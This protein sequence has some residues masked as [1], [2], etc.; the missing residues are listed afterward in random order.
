MK[1]NKIK[2]HPNLRPFKNSK[3]RHFIWGLNEVSFEISTEYVRIYNFRPKQLERYYYFII[4]AMKKIK[5]KSLSNLQ[6]FKNVKV[7]HS[8]WG[9]NEV[10]FE[11]STEYVQMH[12]FRPKQ[13]ERYNYF[14]IYAVKKIKIKSHPN[15]RP[16]KNTK[17][18]LFIWGLNE[19]SFEIST[20]HVRIYNFRPKQ[21]ERYSY[22]IVYAMKKIKIK[23]HPNLRPFK[24]TKV[25]HFIWGL[26]EV[27]FEIST[28]YVRIYNFRPKQLE[29][30]YYFIIYAMKK[31]KIKSLSNLQPFKNVKVRHS[32]WGFNEVSF[33]ISTEYVQMHNF[34]PK[35]LE[36]YNYF[37]I[38]AVK[39]IK[40]KSHPN[41]RPFKNTKVR[42][43]IWGLNEVSFEISTEYVRIYNFRPKQ[44]ERYYYFIIYAMKKIKI[45]SLSNLQPF[46]NVKVRHSIW[47]FNEVSFEISTE[48]VQMHNFQPKQLER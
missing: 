14:I 8:I 35:Q 29:R 41:L 23:S 25:R 20:E 24:N 4:Y 32:I 30:Y 36:R 46:K 38:Y 18:R 39:K 42:H 11:I 13:L 19:V 31:I 21:L 34:R 10:S 1:K 44:L 22:F 12:N 45:K 37:I 7:R 16:F 2:S 33:E 5:I 26:N 17:V 3:V 43:F 47:G 9:F 6:P 40:I 28:E 15:L 48:Y 27:S